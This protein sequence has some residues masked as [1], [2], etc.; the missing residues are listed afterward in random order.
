MAKINK[1][2][3]VP[4]LVSMKTLE[5]ESSALTKKM[6]QISLKILEMFC[7]HLACTSWKCFVLG[8]YTSQTLG[9]YT[10]V[11]QSPARG[12]DPAREAFQSGPRAY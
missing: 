5:N 11:P 4:V 2:H 12:P 9:V 3:L 1:K 6:I 10:S 7:K 8:V